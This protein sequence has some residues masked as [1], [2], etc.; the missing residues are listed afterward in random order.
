MKTYKSF[1][2]W[3][4]DVTDSDPYPGVDALLNLTKGVTPEELRKM[5]DAIDESCCGAWEG[6]AEVNGDT[7]YRYLDYGH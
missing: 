1:D 4:D 3:Y 6:V 2:E 5:A 7:Y